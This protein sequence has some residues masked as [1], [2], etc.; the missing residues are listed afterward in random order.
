[1]AARS[2]RGMAASY[3]ASN[4]AAGLCIAYTRPGTAAAA[5]LSPAVRGALRSACVRRVGLGLLAAGMVGIAP[6]IPG[7]PLP[8]RIDLPS[9]TPPRGG[10]GSEGFVLKGVDASDRSGSSVSTAGDVNG[11]GIDDVI[12][13]AFAASPGGQSEAGESYLIFGRATA[14]PAVFQL[15]NLFPVAGGDGSAGVVLK[16]IDASDKSGF[17]VNGA[18]DVNGDG[19]DDVIIGAK[20]AD[21]N[22]R[23]YAGESYV[24]FGRATDFPPVFEL[25]SLFPGAGGDGNAGFVQAATPMTSRGSL[26]AMRGTSMAMASTT[27]SSARSMPLPTTDGL[28]VRVAWSSA[29]R[30]GF[31]PS[32]SSGVCFPAL[33]ATAA[34]ALC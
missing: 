27:S 2:G 23:P 18:G 21:P 3:V 13:G 19:I 25:R 1:M 7:T 4:H 31:R 34:M 22:G 29:A 15:R 30:Q 24:V 11:D 17:S 6:A 9:E 16:G 10:D 8:D 26:S 14:F 12:V 33:A 32:S 28:R 5:R 20:Y